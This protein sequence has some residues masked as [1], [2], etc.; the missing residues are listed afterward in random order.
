MKI[1]VIGLGK[2]G[3]PLSLVFAKAGFEVYGIDVSGTKIQ[4]ILKRERF[5]EPHVNEYLE[6]YGNNLTVSTDYPLLKNC[7]VVT[8]ITQTPSLP[9]GKFDLNY[10]TSALKQ[11]HKVNPTCLAVISSNINIGSIDKLSK[12][13]KR[14]CHNPEFVKQGSIIHD[15]EN[16]KYVVIGAYTKE[17]GEQVANIWRKVHDKP[18]YIVKP[19]EAEIIKLS[20][21]VSFALGITFANMIGELCEKFNV[22]ASKVLDIIYR[23]RRNYKAGLGF[24]GP[25]LL[26]NTNV[27]TIDGLKPIC[28]IK[29]GDKV[30]TH[31]GKLQKVTK[32]YKTPYR[33]N[34]IKIKHQGVEIGIT[35]GHM[36]F[37]RK[38]QR[39]NSYYAQG[40]LRKN[41]RRTISPL[42][43]IPIGEISDDF[44]F[45]YPK[46][47]FQSG[48][49][50]EFLES[51]K[52]WARRQVRVTPEFMRLVGYYLA[53]GWVNQ[54]SKRMELS[55]NAKEV[56]YIKD[57]QDLMEA[58]F[59]AKLTIHKSACTKTS[60]RLRCTSLIVSKFFYK[61]LGSGAK[62]KRIPWR[63]LNTSR[64]CRIELLKGLFRGD[65]HFSKDSFIYATVSHELFNQVKLILL[66][67]G[68]AFCSRVVPK[69]G[70][71]DKSYWIKI[72]GDYYR[73]LKQIFQL[74]NEGPKRK[75]KSIQSIMTALCI[76]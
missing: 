46:P 72:N 73:K 66:D 4:Q 7:S 21:N 51:K 27:Q 13:H 16:P 45:A 2:L 10:V 20:S 34:I 36:V 31:K 23:D 65:G 44:L 3:L 43:W 50:T 38:I 15:F 49:L 35:P 30:L 17:D 19:V 71:H 64:E 18:I 52:K 57:A 62:N 11:L 53:E 58:I 60:T 42:S 54:K 32:I 33:G 24:M 25:C 63:W 41:S 1:G 12:I 22:D 9:N 39:P 56:E 26:P 76:T 70:M 67:L 74:E 28:T 55:F 75:I 48:N 37:G 6:K 47:D 5:F 40:K 59:H 8:I 14:I 61:M 69:H 29:K 68:I